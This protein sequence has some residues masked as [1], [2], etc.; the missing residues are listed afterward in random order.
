MERINGET[1][2]GAA[3]TLLGALFI[4]AAQIN[5]TWVAAIPAAL[6][7]IAVGIALIVLGRY[8]TIKSNRLHPHTEE[9][10]SH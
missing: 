4:F 1:I 2:A 7:L 8:T 6:I 10:S 5:A 9:H 3:L